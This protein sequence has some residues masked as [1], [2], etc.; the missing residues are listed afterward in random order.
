MSLR[1]VG[2]N[3]GARYGERGEFEG[4]IFWGEFGGRCRRR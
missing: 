2:K 4:G 1:V 3:D